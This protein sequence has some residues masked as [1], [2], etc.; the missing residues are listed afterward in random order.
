MWFLARKKN[1]YPWDY[2]PKTA[3]SEFEMGGGLHISVPGSRPSVF[4]KK[5]GLF[6]SDYALRHG[7]LKL[8]ALILTLIPG[9]T[10]PN[11]GQV[12][13]YPNPGQV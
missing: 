12:P 9:H 7:S 8:F 3:G 10:V 2:T 11:I 6:N 5:N 13:R 4:I 1:D